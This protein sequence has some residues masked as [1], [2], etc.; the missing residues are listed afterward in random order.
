MRKKNMRN[1]IEKILLNLIVI[2]T[3]TFIFSGCAVIEGIFKVG[4]WAGIILVLVIVGIIFFI[5][6]RFRK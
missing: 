6:S 3:A 4:L 5:I 2:S 1:I